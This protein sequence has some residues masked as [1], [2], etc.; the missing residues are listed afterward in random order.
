MWYIKVLAILLIYLPIIIKLPR[1]QI[2][3]AMF[4]F[5]GLQISVFN[6][7]IPCAN[8]TRCQQLR[9]VV[10]AERLLIDFRMT[11]E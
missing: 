2:A 10:M 5:S 1:L 7:Q 6:L 3:L 8:F 11:H 4:L 9:S